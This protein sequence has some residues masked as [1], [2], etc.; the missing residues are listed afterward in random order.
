MDRAQGVGSLVLVL[1]GGALL[2][3]VLASLPAQAPD[4]TSEGPSWIGED[5]WG[6][7]GLDLAAQALLVLTGVLGVLLVL[8][9]REAER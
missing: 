1:A 7:R 9:G 4:P 2:V 8:G 6:V 5:L 3:A